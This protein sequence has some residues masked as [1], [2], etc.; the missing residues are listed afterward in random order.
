MYNHSR[1]PLLP[2][3]VTLSSK[4]ILERGVDILLT[5]MYYQSLDETS[6]L[7]NTRI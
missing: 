4:K 1:S 6:A 5:H 2:E 3:N 7:L